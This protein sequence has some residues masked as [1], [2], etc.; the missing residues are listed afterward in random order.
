[1]KTPTKAVLLV[2]RVP[3]EAVARVNVA[4]RLL[5]EAE[6]AHAVRARTFRWDK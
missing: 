4:A 6:K 1:M 5:T 2:P 3:P